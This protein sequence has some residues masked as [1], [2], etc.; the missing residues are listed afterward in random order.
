MRVL[1]LLGVPGISL[2]TAI[3]PSHVGING[4][5]LPDGD[6][7]SPKDLQFTGLPEI[8]KNGGVET[9]KL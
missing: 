8:N 1:P 3:D 9:I 5:I 6:M 2:V 7:P 4:C